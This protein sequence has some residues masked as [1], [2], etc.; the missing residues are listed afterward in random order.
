MSAPATPEYSLIKK[1]SEIGSGKP[2]VAEPSDDERKAL[3]RR[4]DLPAIHSMKA[5]FTLNPASEKF[6]FEGTIVA[7]VVQSCAISGQEIP[8]RIEEAFKIAF[9]SASD[10]SSSEEEVELTADDCDVMEYQGE[11]IDLGE[12]LAQTLY[13]ALDPYPRAPNAEK[14]ARAK[15]LKSEAE[16]GP[17]GA[18]AALKDKLD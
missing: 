8:V 15:G 4:F 13:L 3:A 14:A 9:V 10:I 16:A 6:L 7:D 11:R 1:L 5:N 18:L 12:A 2:E 17:F